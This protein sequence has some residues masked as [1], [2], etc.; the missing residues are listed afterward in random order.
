M[1]EIRIRPGYVP[2]LYAGLNPIHVCNPGPAYEPVS[3]NPVTVTE[4]SYRNCVRP[5]LKG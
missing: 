4:L 3:M 1:V 2:H 5:S